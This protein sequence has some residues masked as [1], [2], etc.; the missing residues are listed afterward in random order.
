M[1]ISV[2]VVGLYKTNKTK[3]CH[4]PT[5]TH[6]SILPMVWDDGETVSSLSVPHSDLSCQAAAGQQHPVTGQ[7]L[8]VLQDE[9]EPN[10][11]D[12]LETRTFL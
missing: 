10:R 4:V 12:E 2:Y 7:T 6:W 1:K 11:G 9:K 3:K 8:D 5:S